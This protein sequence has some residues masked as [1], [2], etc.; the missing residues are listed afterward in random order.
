MERAFELF[1]KILPSCGRS[2]ILYGHRISSVESMFEGVNDSLCISQDLLIKFIERHIASGWKFISLDE[3]TDQIKNSNNKSKSKQIVLTFDDGYQDNITNG[4]DIFNSYSIPVTIYLTTNFL[5]KKIDLWWYRLEHLIK[6][7]HDHLYF[8][9]MI[10]PTNNIFEKNSSFLKLREIALNSNDIISNL[11]FKWLDDQYSFSNIAYSPQAICWDLLKCHLKN[12]LLTIGSHTISHR[13]LSSLADE[14]C[15]YELIESKRI[16]EKSLSIK[17][18]HTSYPFG[19]INEATARE[20]RLAALAG[21]SS[22][23]TTNY[24]F[25][26]SERNDQILF[27]LPRIHFGHGNQ[28]LDSLLIRYQLK[29]YLYR[30]N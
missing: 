19:T 28:F 10:F 16:I 9:N 21:Y 7:S 2:A 11:F 5:D 6:N 24:G 27:Q 14:E 29:K 1:A 15:F 26:S 30:L 18:S 4:M 20:Y 17:V 22:A 12:P 25:I 23:V 8:N 3:L 13:N